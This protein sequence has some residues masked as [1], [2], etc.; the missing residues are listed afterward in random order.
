[1]RRGTP[2]KFRW[3]IFPTGKILLEQ[4]WIEKLEFFLFFNAERNCKSGG[5]EFASHLFF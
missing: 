5:R 4:L 1:M 3:S 2:A